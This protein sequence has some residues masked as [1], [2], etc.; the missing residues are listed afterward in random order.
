MA[1]ERVQKILAKAGV[2]SRRKAEE[3]ITLGEVTI[4]GRTA[5]LGDKAEWGKD[6]IKVRGKLLHSIEDPVYLVFH[7][8]KNVISS[9][10]D[11]EGRSSI[12]DYL[13]QVKERV[14]PIGRLDYTSE[15][16]LL[17]TNDGGF[18]E[19][20][21]NR[22]DI[23]RVY[24]V[25]MRTP[26][27]PSEITF[28]LSKGARLGR[29]MIKPFSVKVIDQYTQKSLVEVVILGAGATDIKS[30]FEARGFLIE[31]IVRKAIGH[32]TLKDLAPGEFRRL[33][34]S[35]AVALLNQPELG[36]RLLTSSP[37]E[38]H[39]Q[40]PTPRPKGILSAVGGRTREFRGKSNRGRESE[41]SGRSPVA[42]ARRF[43][44]KR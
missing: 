13:D 16:L 36:M 11:P 44:P 22:D 19:K 42:K 7:K 25:K 33:K 34:P 17:L 26:E 14:F 18:A 2:S 29:K 3:M 5:K 20:L 10:G 9:L 35:Q 4:N 30:L 24:H 15:G 38:L 1:L 21:Q 27:K 32:I 37:D 31:R 41:R 40:E 6:A 8:P 28:R 43:A 12:T 39:P 23:P